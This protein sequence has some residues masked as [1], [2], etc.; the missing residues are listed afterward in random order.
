MDNVR[1]AWHA[2]PNDEMPTSQGN[3][4]GSKRLA[5]EGLTASAAEKRASRRTPA[6]L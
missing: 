3:K 5:E 6:P 2:G 1:R 4:L